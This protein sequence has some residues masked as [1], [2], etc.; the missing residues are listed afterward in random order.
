VAST[1]LIKS[2][3]RRSRSTGLLVAD[4]VTNSAIARSA[5]WPG[6]VK[7]SAKDLL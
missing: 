2:G 1:A 5:L 3:L 4:H 7:T 6:R